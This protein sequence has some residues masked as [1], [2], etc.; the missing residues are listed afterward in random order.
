MTTIEVDSAPTGADAVINVV[1]YG[2]R[3]ETP[4]LARALAAADPRVRVHEIALSDKAH[5]WNE[6]A[7][8][9]AGDAEMH[10]FIDAAA[11]P[12]KGALKAL[13][14]ELDDVETTNVPFFDLAVPTSVPGVPSEVLV[15]RNT[16]PDGAAFDEQAKKLAQAFADNFKQFEDRVSDAVK[17]A[18]PRA[19]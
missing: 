13:A 8:R 18:A 6:Y 17:S 7:H 15:P 11:R 2:S 16:W 1:D 5:A 10:V 12:S 19:E 14:G 9:L 3:D 4:R